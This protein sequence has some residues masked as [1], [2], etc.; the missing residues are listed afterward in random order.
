M[1]RLT[2]SILSLMSLSVMTMSD[3]WQKKCVDGSRGW[4]ATVQNDKSTTSLTTEQRWGKPVDATWFI[5]VRTDES[6]PALFKHFDGVY[7]PA[8]IGYVYEAA[9]A[10]WTHPIFRST[11]ENAL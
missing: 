10:G 9:R 5:P 2:V 1:G 8:P 6:Y 7:R 3:G 4:S 11:P